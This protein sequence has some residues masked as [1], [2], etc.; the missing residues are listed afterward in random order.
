MCA[1][2]EKYFQITSSL[3]N[4]SMLNNLKTTKTLKSR[5]ENDLSLRQRRYQKKTTNTKFEIENILR[6]KLSSFFKT[7]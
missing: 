3:L 4:K 2:V 7:Q 1:F 6:L 5:C